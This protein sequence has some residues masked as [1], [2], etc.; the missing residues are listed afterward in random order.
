MQ[1]P[2]KLTFRD[3]EKTPDI[4]E[5]IEKQVE[6]LHKFCPYMTSCRVAVERPHGSPE[7]GNAYRIRLDITVPPSK[8]ILVKK[9]PQDSEMHDDLRTVILNAFRAARRQ[10]DRLVDLQ[11]GQMKT[12]A[13]P[14]AFV[15]RLYPELDYGFLKTPDD[16]DI[17]FHRNSVLNGDFER[18][19]V[20]TQVRFAEEE[21][22]K[23]PQASSVQVI[24]KPGQR[25]SESAWDLPTAPR[26]WQ[27]AGRRHAVVRKRATKA[28]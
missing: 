12:H 15:T 3:V 13:E 17:Y 1:V 20:G 27:A 25:M 23:G 8:D 6:K 14:V 7:S 16:R 11:H 21:G 10:L 28:R 18:L 9:D 4:V 26:G 2:L 5:L 19:S 24:D 22:L